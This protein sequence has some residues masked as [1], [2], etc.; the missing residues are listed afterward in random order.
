MRLL[1]GLLFSVF[2]ASAQTP[3]DRL[4]RLLQENILIDTHVD[5]P[6]Y[7]V[8]EHYDLGEEHGYYEADIPRLKRGHVGAVFFGIPVEPQNF[9]PHLWIPRALELIDAVHE[10]AR[11]HAADLEIALTAEDVRRIHRAGKVAALMGVEG[12]HMIQDSLPMLRTYYR[13]GVRYMT[14]TH[15]KT[16]DWADSSGD[17][18]A[19][20]GLTDFG[21][22]VV[23][24]MNRLGMMVDISHVSDKTFYDVLAV[25]RA[26]VIAS[27]S[28]LRAY[29][30]IPRNM[31]DGMIRA[32]AAKGGVVGIN[33]NI[34]YL[35]PKASNVFLGYND[36]RN[37]EIADML[38][39]NGSNPERWEMKR[40]IQQRYR[41]SLPKVGIDTV[42]RVID[43]AV[44]VAGADHVG[45]GSDFD[46]VSGMVPAGMEDVSKYP[47]LVRGLIGLGY[48]DGDIR[49]IMG[50]NLLRVMRA[51]EQA[52]GK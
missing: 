47:D 39:M 24:E 34:A 43:H 26:P 18:A 9:P 30:D 5:T 25:S 52:A 35:D 3:A 36:Q 2:L 50:E 23:R 48:T 22:D 28:S 15:F 27:H 7:M 14:L 10:Q 17:V 4:N 32:L 13:L 29:V 45:F 41:A 12:G 11:T 31:S 38:G 1:C 33:F 46:G 21:R 49:K 44:K 51:A 6:W 16:N 40:A 42:L 20:N 19:H 8:D 37:R